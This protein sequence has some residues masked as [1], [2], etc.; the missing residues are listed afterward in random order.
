MTLEK[1][2]ARRVVVWDFPV[3]L[4]HWSIV[5]LIP[6]AWWTFEVDRMALHRA[7]GYG[8]L[9]L[10]AVRLAWGFVGS[11][12]ARFANFICGPRRVTAYLSGRVSHHVGHNPLGGLSV[13]LLLSVLCV[14]PLLGLFAADQEG[15]DS[16]PLSAF[17]S[18]DHAQLA[19]QLHAVFFY[20]L[21]GLVTLHLAAIVFYAVRGKNIVW[22][23][24]RGWTRLAPGVAA[25]WQAGKVREAVAVLATALLFG[26]LWWWGG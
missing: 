20:V 13:A 25:P 9:A 3:R 11:E 7:A 6:F 8:V 16:G 24:F 23:M 21:L 14:Q 15:L 17:V 2:D 4:I 26:S 5:L 19:E 10:V 18:D 22:P 1:P 12:T